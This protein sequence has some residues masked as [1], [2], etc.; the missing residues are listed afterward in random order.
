MEDVVMG[1]GVCL[2]PRKSALGRPISHYYQNDAW[3][4]FSVFIVNFEH[5]LLPILV[6][7]LLNLSR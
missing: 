7:L 2:C 1:F 6:F 3:R 4:R 5:I